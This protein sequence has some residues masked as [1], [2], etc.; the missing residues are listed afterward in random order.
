MKDDGSKRRSRRDLLKTIALGA[1]AASTAG[2]TATAAQA[3][4]PEGAADQDGYRETDY[5]RRYYA[6]AR[7]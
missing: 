2:V 1:A 4:A 6:L 5:V 3:D 7:E